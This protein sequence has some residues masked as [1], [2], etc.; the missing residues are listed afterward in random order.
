VVATD[1]GAGDGTDFIMSKRGFSELGLNAAAS[2]QLLKEGVVDIAFKRVPCTFPSNIKLHVQESSKNPGYFAVV[3]L[4]VNGINDITAVELW[5]VN[6]SYITMFKLL[7]SFAFV[8][9]LELNLVVEM[10][11]MQRGQK[12]WE[13]LRRAYGAVF[14]FANPPSGEIRLRF[15]VGY[16]YWLLPKIPIPANWKS[17]AT[18]DSQVQP[19]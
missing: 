14:D 3:L 17:G 10:I 16:K 9:V 15:Q 11:W 18:Y 5:Q 4:N 6:S 7:S 1:Y 8:R 2:A 13:P 19:Y 12:R